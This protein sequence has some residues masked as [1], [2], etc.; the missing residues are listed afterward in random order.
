MKR[1]HVSLALLWLSHGETLWRCITSETVV[2]HFLPILFGD[3]NLSLLQLPLQSRNKEINNIRYS[4]DALNKI[5]RCFANVRLLPELSLECLFPTVR[6]HFP[7][8]MFKFM[9]NRHYISISIES[10]GQASHWSQPTDTNW[11]ADSW[12]WLVLNYPSREDWNLRL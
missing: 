8:V 4:S 10:Q 11:G 2:R 6:F 12:N 3:Y 1:G 9:K 7:F 5:P